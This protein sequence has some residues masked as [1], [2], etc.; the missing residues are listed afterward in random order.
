MIIQI[1][2]KIILILILMVVFNIIVIIVIINKYKYL[3]KKEYLD[4]ILL[5]IEKWKNGL[6]LHDHVLLSFLIE[7][8]FNN[9]LFFYHTLFL[10]L[11]LN[12]IS[13]FLFYFIIINS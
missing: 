9:L 11:T 6:F 12:S 5:K 13:Y 10:S 1:M 2:V 3:N 7:S 4:S 8:F